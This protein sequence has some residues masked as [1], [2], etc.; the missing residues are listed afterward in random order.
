MREFIESYRGVS[1]YRAEVIFCDPTVSG[2]IVDPCEA[3]V[4]GWRLL[5]SLESVKEEI[6]RKLGPP[7]PDSWPPRL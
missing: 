3:Q 6:D 2:Q 7:R 4:N 5:G 1:I